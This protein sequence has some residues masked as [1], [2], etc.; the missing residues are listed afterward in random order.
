M[1]V[2]AYNLHVL[3]CCN[4]HRQSV[5]VE[6]VPSST[7]RGNADFVQFTLAGEYLAAIRP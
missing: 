2:K 6:L 3:Y 5:F 1:R 4:A 7:Y